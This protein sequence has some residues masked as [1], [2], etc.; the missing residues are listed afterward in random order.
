MEN[1]QN[2]AQ[3]TEIKSWDDF[4]ELLSKQ[5]KVLH[6]GTVTSKTAENALIKINYAKARQDGVIIV[7]EGQKQTTYRCPLGSISPIHTQITSCNRRIRLSELLK[8]VEQFTA[9]DMVDTNVY[10]FVCPYGVGQ[11][12][13][14]KAPL[15]KNLNKEVM[16]IMVSSTN[17]ID[18][19]QKFPT[20]HNANDI[21]LA[22]NEFD[23]FQNRL[24][25]RFNYL[26]QKIKFGNGNDGIGR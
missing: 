23:I 9:I 20:L 7:T 25:A 18:L 14:T 6:L 11:L 8:F 26:V 19:L 2:E 13:F 22:P 17:G 15:S 24:L 1:K 12:S 16:H 21:T 10:K 5:T 3:K 4:I